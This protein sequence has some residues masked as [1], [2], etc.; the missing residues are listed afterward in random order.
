MFAIVAIL[1]LLAMT[2][3]QDVALADQYDNPDQVGETKSDVE[4]EQ[5]VLIKTIELIV[6]RTTKHIDQVG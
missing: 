1:V 4:L 6:I 3:L 5:F 2:M